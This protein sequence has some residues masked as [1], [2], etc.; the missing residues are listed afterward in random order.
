MIAA[1][2]KQIAAL[3]DFCARNRFRDHMIAASLKPD[4]A[5][6]RANELNGFPRS[7][8]R[9]LIEASRSC[10]S[11][12]RSARGFRDHMI[13]A[14]LKRVPLAAPC[15]GQQCFRDHMIAA[16]LK[17]IWILEP[18]PPFRS[19][20]DHMIA[21]SLKRARVAHGRFGRSV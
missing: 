5:A 18:A 13:A 9:G 3:S 20:R 1:S 4:R 21:A 16:S 10:R 15:R 12:H 6:N 19:F 11:T 2:L 17:P 8:D 7:Y 14:S